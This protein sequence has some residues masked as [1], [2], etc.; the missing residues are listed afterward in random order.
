MKD[1][2]KELSSIAKELEKLQGKLEKAILEADKQP[3]TKKAA[4]SSRRKTS[5]K[6]KKVD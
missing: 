3:G 2:Q 6:A 4:K 1:I 5:K